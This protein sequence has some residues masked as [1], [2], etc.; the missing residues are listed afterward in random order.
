MTTDETPVVAFRRARKHYRSAWGHRV[1][2]VRVAVPA[3]EPVG[4]VTEAERTVSRQTGQ[5][6]YLAPS[7]R[8]VTDVYLRL[9][10]R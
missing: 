3:S 8:S 7:G 1:G 6:N 9:V 5:T 10:L 4:L 2:T